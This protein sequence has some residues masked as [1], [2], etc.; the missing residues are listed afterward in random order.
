MVSTL[1]LPSRS[2]A[3]KVVMILKRLADRALQW[4]IRKYSAARRNHQR[5]SGPMSLSRR[6]A[7]ASKV[8]V[9]QLLIES[10]VSFH[11]MSLD[12]TQTRWSHMERTIPQ[13]LML[14]MLDFSRTRNFFRVR[15][16]SSY[17]NKQQT[18]LM[19]YRSRILWMPSEKVPVGAKRLVAIPKHQNVRKLT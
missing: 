12:R 6:R 17:P 4:R 14:W 13:R 2:T 7:S 1:R 8:Q 9:G 16:P 11:R 19:S 15:A 3:S 5:I 18:M 10:W